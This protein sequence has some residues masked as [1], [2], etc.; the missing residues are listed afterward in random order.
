MIQNH[1]IQVPSEHMCE[2]ITLGTE[3]VEA[4]YV[5][6]SNYDFDRRIR[7]MQENQDIL[8]SRLTGIYVIAA[9]LVAWIYTLQAAPLVLYRWGCLGE[10]DILTVLGEN[11]GMEMGA[12]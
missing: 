4:H 2:S 12:F 10:D 7:E 9:T 11:L 5:A 1:L 8:P 6:M 3:I